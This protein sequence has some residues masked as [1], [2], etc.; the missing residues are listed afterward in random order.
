MEKILLDS[1]ST[2]FFLFVFVW[3]NYAHTWQE[4]IKKSRFKTST[5][6]ALRLCLD[7]TNSSKVTAFFCWMFIP[8]NTP[9]NFRYNWSIVVRKKLYLLPVG[10]MKRLFMPE[11]SELHLVVIILTICWK[12]LGRRKGTLRCNQGKQRNSGLNYGESILWSFIWKSMQIDSQEMWGKPKPQNVLFILRTNLQND[13]M[14]NIHRAD[15]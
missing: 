4:D 11:S 1:K 10:I 7:H 15:R 9:A 5:N 2:T 12:Q 6:H 8:I 13:V 3:V 14:H